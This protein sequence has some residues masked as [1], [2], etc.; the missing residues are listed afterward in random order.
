[1]F[2]AD[3][4]QSFTAAL[5]CGVREG[6]SSGGDGQAQEEGS[7]EAAAQYSAEAVDEEKRVAQAEFASKSAALEG[8]VREAAPV[9]G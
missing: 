9:Q 5:P 6:L 8:E 3:R 2:E 4:H 1:M 7:A